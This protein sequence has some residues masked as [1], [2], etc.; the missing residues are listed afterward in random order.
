ML[1][2]LVTGVALQVDKGVSQFAERI[3]SSAL[4]DEVACAALQ[5]SREFGTD[6]KCAVNHV[7]ESAGPEG[8]TVFIVFFRRAWA[9]APGKPIGHFEVFDEEGLHLKW[10]MNANVLDP[11]DRVLQLGGAPAVVVQQLHNEVPCGEATSS[12]TALLVQTVH[13][14]SLAAPERPILSLFIGPPTR[15][16]AVVRKQPGTCETETM[17]DVA[18]TLCG[19]LEER[20][21]AF[22]WTWSVVCRAQSCTLSVGPSKAVRAGRGTAAFRWAEAQQVLGPSGSAD[23]GFMKFD[24]ANEGMALA[25]FTAG[26]GFPVGCGKRVEEKCPDPD[27]ASP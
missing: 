15:E 23:G 26:H 24:A 13:V 11:T 12:A 2:L 10:F 18:M 25:A 6:E 16:T 27:A 22:A 17:G 19:P 9:G 7:I 4:R 8:K 3:R 14:V 21:P 1:F 5:R 20:A